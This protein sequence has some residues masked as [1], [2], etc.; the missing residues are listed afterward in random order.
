LQFEWAALEHLN[1]ELKG[2]AT[3]PIKTYRV[4]VAGEIGRAEKDN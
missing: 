1:Q 4:I 2:T 3:E